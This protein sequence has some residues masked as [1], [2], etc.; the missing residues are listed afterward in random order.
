[1][2]GVVVSICSRT[3][4]SPISRSLA[5]AMRS[6][7]DRVRRSRR[8]TTSVS[9]ARMW[10]SALVSC[11]RSARVLVARLVHPRAQPASR[12]ASSW[13]SGAR[14]RSTHARIAKSWPL[15]I[16]LPVPTARQ[17]VRRPAVLCTPAGGVRR[18]LR[19][20]SPTVIRLEHTLSDRRASPAAAADGTYFRTPPLLDDGQARR[21][22]R[23]DR[24]HVVDRARLGR[25]EGV[26]AALAEQLGL[27]LSV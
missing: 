10:S 6:V 21:H 5:I 25:G 2:H 12:S 1:M 27:E 15:A 20:L 4:R 9:P 16:W 13:S 26:G 11:R 8:Q 19:Q 24:A 22:G 14:Q 23:M 17:R 7:T 3:L 18:S